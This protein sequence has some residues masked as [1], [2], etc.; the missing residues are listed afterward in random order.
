MPTSPK[1]TG[2]VPSV[3]STMVKMG[4]VG[5]ATVAAQD[6]H[7]AETPR[8][9]GSWHSQR[10]ILP[11]RRIVLATRRVYP[12]LEVYRRMRP[13]Y[14]LNCDAP[15]NASTSLSASPTSCTGEADWPCFEMAVSTLRP[16][17]LGRIGCPRRAR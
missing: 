9:V 11:R 5:S 14:S 17:T 16:N 10:A 6:R 7:A 12:T 8:P 4:T 13:G 3:V 2:G 15:V 1:L